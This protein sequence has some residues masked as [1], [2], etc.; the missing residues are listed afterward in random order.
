ML[1][2]LH[3]RGVGDLQEMPDYK[4]GTSSIVLRATEVVAAVAFENRGGIPWVVI[5]DV[6]NGQSEEREIEFQVRASA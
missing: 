5:R 2:C 4:P 3:E 6:R 1:S